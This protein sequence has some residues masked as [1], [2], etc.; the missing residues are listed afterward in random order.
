MMEDNC[1]SLLYKITFEILKS[2]NPQKGKNGKVGEL[3]PEA[4]TRHS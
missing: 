2:K 3:T 1:Q 4:S